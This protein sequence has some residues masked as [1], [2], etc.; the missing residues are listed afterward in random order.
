MSSSYP[1]SSTACQRAASAG[2]GALDWQLHAPVTRTHPARASPRSDPTCCSSARHPWLPAPPGLPSSL[3]AKATALPKKGCSAITGPSQRRTE[4]RERCARVKGGVGAYE[5][6]RERRGADCSY[7]NV[8]H[9]VGTTTFFLGTTAQTDAHR[10]D[11]TFRYAAVY[12]RCEHR[13][14][15]P[16]AAVCNADAAVSLSAALQHAGVLSGQR[17]NHCHVPLE[18]R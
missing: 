16:Q 2:P 5:T 7:E 10:R 17:G 15:M 4:Q 3:L 18:G 13:S 11:S 1:A 9:R 14:F 12:Q 6:Q 8:R